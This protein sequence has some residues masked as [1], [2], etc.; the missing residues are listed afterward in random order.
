MTPGRRTVPVAAAVTVQLIY[1]YM[2]SLPPRA[3]SWHGSAKED[4]T[5]VS[6][7]VA[8]EDSESDRARLQCRRN[9]ASGARARDHTRADSDPK[10]A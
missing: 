6:L 9:A 2:E 10:A 3:T 4:G 1:I 7:A 5:G 8:A